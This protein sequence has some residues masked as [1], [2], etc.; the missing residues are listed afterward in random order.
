MSKY[1]VFELAKEFHTESKVV[2]DILK[3]G[4]Y[5]VANH[6]SSV[7]DEERNAIKNHFEKKSAPAAK[8]QPKAA[9]EKKEHPKQVNHAEKQ[10][11]FA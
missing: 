6:L 1:R 9:P 10:N 8:N 11:K 7:G 3:K 2:L 5:K 4:N